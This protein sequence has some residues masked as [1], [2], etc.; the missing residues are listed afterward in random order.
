MGTLTDELW[1]NYVIGHPVVT[2]V[3]EVPGGS[4]IVAANTPL[5]WR[6]S[7]L[8]SQNAFV[9][10]TTADIFCLRPFALAIWRR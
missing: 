5:E 9:E 10:A 7:G 4:V 2:N 8:M 1:D 3:A 6:D